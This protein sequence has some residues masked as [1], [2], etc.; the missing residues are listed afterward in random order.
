[1]VWIGLPLMLAGL[2]FIAFA[3]PLGGGSSQRVESLNER[4]SPWS[5][6]DPRGISARAYR[7]R[8]AAALFAGA[9]FTAIAWLRPDM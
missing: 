3:Q 2:A 5:R 4:R 8:G 1:M 9:V 6:I 7:I